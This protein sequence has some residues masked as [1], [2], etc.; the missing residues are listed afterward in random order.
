MNSVASY[1]IGRHEFP[2]LDDKLIIGAAA[3]REALYC[4]GACGFCCLK[5]APILRMDRMG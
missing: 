2:R 4:L 3:K 1:R 5:A